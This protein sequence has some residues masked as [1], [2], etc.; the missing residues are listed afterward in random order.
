M[1]IVS[2]NLYASIL[3]KTCFFYYFIVYLYEFEKDFVY[4]SGEDYGMP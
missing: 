2:L 1:H 4:L 3:W